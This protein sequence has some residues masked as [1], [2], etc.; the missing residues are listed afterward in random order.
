MF[1]IEDGQN[2]INCN[3]D[4]VRPDFDTKALIENTVCMRYIDPKLNNKW[5]GGASWNYIDSGRSVGSSEFDIV[6]EVT[7][8]TERVVFTYKNINYETFEEAVNAKNNDEERE[9]RLKEELWE[10]FKAIVPKDGIS[11]IAL[12]TS[13]QIII[14]FKDG[15][16]MTF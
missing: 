7:G 14:S 9:E 11:N 6:K 8:I 5:K 16:K 12:N 4:R 1:K 2:Y 10:C 3:G 13:N 15:A